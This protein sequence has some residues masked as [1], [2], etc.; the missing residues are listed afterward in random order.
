MAPDVTVFGPRGRNLD[1]AGSITLGRDELEAVRLADLVGMDQAGAGQAMGVS[2]ATFGR[3]VVGAR[4]KIA[5]ALVGGAALVIT[6]GNVKDRSETRHFGCLE[7]ERTFEEPYGTG[8]PG[9][10]PLC[11][12]RRF[13]RVRSER[14]AGRECRGEGA[15]TTRGER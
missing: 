14:P 11:G 8:R 2:R 7:C 1:A 5:R 4:R 12:S 15:R 9:S 6:G 10:C 13:R 3:I